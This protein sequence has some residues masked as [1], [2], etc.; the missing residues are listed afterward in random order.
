MQ[1]KTVQ[2]IV[3]HPESTISD[4]GMSPFANDIAVATNDSTVL[5]YR[6]AMPDQEFE[7]ELWTQNQNDVTLNKCN[8]AL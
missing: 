4:C 3:W 6:C 2:C 8:F 5:V 7:G 1:R